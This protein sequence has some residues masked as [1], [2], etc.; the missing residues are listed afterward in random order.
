MPL[1]SIVVPTF[2][3]VA[4]L[5]EAVESA[6]AQRHPELEVVVSDNASEDGT[7]EAALAWRADPRFRYHRNATNLGMVANWRRAVFEHARGD[8][9]LILSDDDRLLDPDYLSKAM[10]LV[11]EH[12]GVVLVYADGYVLD[13]STG[14][15]EAL[16]LP[17]GTV[18]EGT[19]VFASRDR[20]LPQDFTLCN[21]LFKRSLALELDAFANPLNICCDSELFLKSCLFGQV[22]VVHDPV[23]L[24]RVHGANLILQR[25]ED[26]RVYGA[27]LDYYLEPRR[28]AVER[29]A[30][31][32]R[33]LRAFDQVTRR[34]MRRTI[35]ALERA[36]PDR[37]DDLVE[38]LWTRE[39][40][41]AFRALLNGRH[42]RRAL[43]LVGRRLRAA[44]G[45]RV[46]RR[47]D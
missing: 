10:A 22:G 14:R 21:V 47:V 9:F 25:H 6:L 32:R 17:F 18:E 3:R 26:P 40:R 4:M 30:L 29:R 34:A 37:V 45:R 38:H 16:R 24:Y 31:T 23:S 20:V 2:N 8:W 36:H 33:Q 46:G 28:L 43:P 12:P 27:M 7:R 1:V 41:L 11:R 42:A 13:E 5:R 19:T 15:T 35:L 44:L 39:P